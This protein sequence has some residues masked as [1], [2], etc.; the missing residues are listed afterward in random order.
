[1]KRIHFTDSYLLSPPASGYRVHDRGRRHRLTSDNQFGT[2]EHGVAVARTRGAACNRFRPRHGDGSQYRKAA[3]QR[4]R[5][6]FEQG[7]GTRFPYQP[8]LRLWL[9]SGTLP[10]LQ[11]E[12]RK[13]IRYRGGQHHPYLYGQQGF[14]PGSMADIERT[15]ESRL[16][17]GEDSGLLDGLR[18]CHGYR[19]GT[20]R[21]G[22]GQHPATG[23]GPFHFRAEDEC[24]YRRN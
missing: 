4:I 23:I 11:A 21:H 17:G 2:H 24:H 12:R 15:T 13:L 22:Q 18:E 20:D 19:A 5:N 1:M 8:F 10:L 3:F 6:R 9:G 7:G 16:Y 14:P